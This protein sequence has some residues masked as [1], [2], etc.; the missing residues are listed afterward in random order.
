MKIYASPAT[1]DCPVT[2][3]AA[4]AAAKAAFDAAVEYCSTCNSVFSVFEL[5]IVVHLATLGRCLIRLFL[6]ARHERLDLQPY[7]QDGKYRPGE[8]YAER[9][10]KTA[11]GEVTYG[12][13]YLTPRGWWQRLFSARRGAGF[14]AGPPVA[15]DDAVG[16][17]FVHTHEFQG[18]PDGV[19]GGA[20]LGARHRDDR[21]GGAGH[22]T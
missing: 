22:G 16:R 19:Q 8:P 18:R 2:S 7:L 12:R 15:M 4:R 11:Y 6:T 17:A 13:R 14:D 5:Q 10:L 9:K 21:T 1:P 3:D 20:Q